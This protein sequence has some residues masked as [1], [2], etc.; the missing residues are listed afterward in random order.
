MKT[1]NPDK[2]E[3]RGMRPEELESVHRM[4]NRAF[5]H[6]P[7][8][9]FDRQ[10]RADPFL[11]PED[12]RILLEKG[13]IRSSVR[14]YFRHVHC[15]GTT[16]KI[17]GIGDVGTDPSAQ[18]RGYASLLMNDAVQYMKSERAVLSFL[19]TKI[20]P[21][22]APFGY[23]TLPTLDLTLRP[24]SPSTALPFRKADLDKDL[25][26]LVRMYDQL[27]RHRS[28]PV[29]RDGRY[30]ERQMGFPRLNPDLFWVVDE[31]GEIV[32]YA[33]GGIE[34]DTLKLLDFG[35][36]LGKEDRLYDH[37]AVMAEA[38]QKKTVRLSYVSQQ[39]VDLFKHWP[40]EVTENTAFMVRLL[41]LDRLSSFRS[42]F[43]PRKILFWE[44]DRF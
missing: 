8:R 40:S 3:I 4:L 43:E 18:G 20:N 10:V 15:G 31:N 6:T 2:V 37:I 36:T 9:F 44:A 35:Y 26:A 29:V 5:P 32:C 13:I 21:F 24:P 7:K 30:W 39:E 28:A 41:Q 33:R 11:R 12:T 14:V 25:G 42:I 34:K 19:F 1:N 17:G 38:S 23:F 16:L 27:N 22:Y